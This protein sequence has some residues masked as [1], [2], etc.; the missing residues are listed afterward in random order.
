MPT[1]RNEEFRLEFI[2][3]TVHTV[4]YVLNTYAACS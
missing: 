4:Q 1:S 3:G 2:T